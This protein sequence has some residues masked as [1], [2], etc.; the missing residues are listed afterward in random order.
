MLTF[1]FDHGEIQWE[2]LISTRIDIF[3]VRSLFLSQRCRAW[4]LAVGFIVFSLSHTYLISTY[5]PIS[6][7]MNCSAVIIIKCNRWHTINMRWPPRRYRCSKACRI[8]ATRNGSARWS[9]CE[10]FWDNSRMCRPTM[11]SACV[12]RTWN[13][14]ATRNTRWAFGTGPLNIH[15]LI[16]SIWNLAG[17]RRLR[18][19][20]RQFGFRWTASSAR[21]AIHTWLQNPTRMQ[22][23]YVPF[24]P[25]PRRLGGA[26]ECSLHRKLRGRPLSVFGSM[27]STQSRCRWCVRMAARRFLKIPRPK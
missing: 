8:R 27:R 15:S 7:R 9:E 21:M 4:L 26:N 18:L 14:A 20:L 24:A 16:I 17:Y 6:I 1:L 12:H 13:Q 11:W 5:F 25:V 19:H 10:R 3:C 23:W 2:L 22:K